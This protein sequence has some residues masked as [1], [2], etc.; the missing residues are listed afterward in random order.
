VHLV[1][2]IIRIYHDARPSECQTD[3]GWLHHLTEVTNSVH[4]GQP[5][6]VINRI[7]NI[8]MCFDHLFYDN[9]L[10]AVVFRLG[11]LIH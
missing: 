5:I 1:G 4:P 7:R 9:Q 8:L 10:G 2:S 6:V 3:H 11:I